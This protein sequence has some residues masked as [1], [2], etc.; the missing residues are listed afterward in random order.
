MEKKA[1]IKEVAKKAGVSVSTVSRVLKDNPNLYIRTETKKRVVRVIRELGF[2]PDIRAQSL[3]GVGTQIIGFIIPN[4]SPFYDQLVWE[5]EDVCHSEEY[6]V[7]ICDSNNDPERERSY[8]DLLE[9]Q[10]VDSIVISTV[11]S[12]EERLRQLI[13]RGIPVILADEDIPG[14]NVPAVLARNYPGSCQATQ[15]LIDLNH[16]KIAYISGP[17][18]VLSGKERLRGYRD[19]LLKNSLSFERKLL[20]KGNYSYA[21]GYKAAQALLEESKDKFTAIFCANDLM[22]LGA[23]RAIQDAGG[24]VPEDYS[25]IGFDDMDFSSISYPQLTTIA[26]PVRKMAVKIFEAIKK[27]MRGDSSQGGKRYRLSTRLVIRQSCRPV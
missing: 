24:Q 26:Q 8:L 23:I 10:K 19:T 25:I 1:T 17:L 9:R 20:K 6:G 4:L 2:K 3:R 13:R 11:G 16:R 27:E 7:L 22:A 15:Y 12:N 21:S 14:L 5:L 18:K